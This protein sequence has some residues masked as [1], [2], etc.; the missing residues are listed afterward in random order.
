MPGPRS[1]TSIRM[2]LAAGLHADL[3]L[4][5]GRAVADRILD[6]VAERLRKQLAV[7][8]Q[9]RRPGRPVELQRRAALLGERV[10]HL[11]ELGGEV[12]DV[13]PGELV[14]AGQRLRAA[15]LEHRRQDP[16]QRIGLADRRFRAA[17][18]VPPGSLVSAAA[19]A[20]GSEPADGRAKV[21]RERVRQQPQLLHQPADAVE[22]GVDLHREPVE[23]IPGA[24]HRHP[25]AEVARADPVG[26]RGDVADAARRRSGR[27]SLRRAA[28]AA[29]RR[30]AR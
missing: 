18:P 15:D 27:G 13:E 3:D 11:G 10:V 1:A 16:D 21:V 6:E 4:P 25:L 23:R 14:A 24:R 9:R 29:R 20:A 5:A 28:R 2:S 7:P 12:A 19:C 8:E 26:D 17:P 30:T 22:H